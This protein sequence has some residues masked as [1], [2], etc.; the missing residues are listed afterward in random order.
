MINHYHAA[1]ERH[2]EHNSRQSR[3]ID[4][5]RVSCGQTAPKITYIER[6][7]SVGPRLCLDLPLVR[8]HRISE[9]AL[10]PPIF[11]SRHEPTLSPEDPLKDRLR[12]LGWCE[13]SESPPT[14][15]SDNGSGASRDAYPS[16]ARSITVSGQHA[17]ACHRGE[18]PYPNR[19]GHCRGCHRRADPSC[20]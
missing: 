3:E 18:L 19:L 14:L 1:G 5:C 13:R 20:I 11:L 8:D 16:R 12:I 10:R 7:S 2:G 15:K 9:W 17:I 4:S 6:A